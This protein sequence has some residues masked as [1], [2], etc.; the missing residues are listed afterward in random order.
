MRP[1][2]CVFALTLLAPPSSHAVAAQA[3]SAAPTKTLNT[4]TPLTTVA[5]NTFIAPEGW[6]VEVRG[7]ATILEPPE[8]GSHI[9]LIDSA[10]NLTGARK[11]AEQRSS[12]AAGGQASATRSA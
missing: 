1:T 10:H 9:A 4:D 6:R 2:I 8:G 7:P 3:T 11:P 12:T 5:G